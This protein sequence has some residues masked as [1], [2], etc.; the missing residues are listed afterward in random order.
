MM[1]TK[2]PLKEIVSELKAKYVGFSFE[3][4]H[5]IQQDNYTLLVYKD[6]KNLSALN[7][8]PTTPLNIMWE[9]IKLWMK[10]VLSK[11]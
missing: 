7:L 6:G 4:K 10:P 1:T 8:N 9:S 11:V 2:A 5:S 3:M